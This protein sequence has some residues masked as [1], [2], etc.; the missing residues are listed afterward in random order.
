MIRE[1]TLFI[2]SVRVWYENINKTIWHFFCYVLYVYD[3][4]LIFRKKL[5]ANNYSSDLKIFVETLTTIIFI[6][7]K[8]VK[9]H[10][11]CN[12]FP[13]KLAVDYVYTYN[14]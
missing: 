10:D 2:E 12:V 5:Q 14:T 8:S 11:D 9:V 4:L 13:T 6:W 3:S 7:E 1:N